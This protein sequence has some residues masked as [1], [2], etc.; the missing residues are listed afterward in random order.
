MG[1]GSEFVPELKGL[2]G[3]V[4]IMS[5]NPIL[6]NKFFAV[7]VSFLIHLAILGQDVAEEFNTRPRV[8][9]E[10]FKRGF[11][12]RVLKLI[13]IPCRVLLVFDGAR[14]LHKAATDAG[15]ADEK[16]GHL[17]RLQELLKRSNL[18]PGEIQELKQLKRKCVSV[19]ED[20]IASAVAVCQEE[21]WQ[22]VCSPFEADF[23]VR[24]L[25]DSLAL[26]ST[27]YLWKMLYSNCVTLFLSPPLPPLLFLS[28][29]CVMLER[30]GIVD[31]CITCDSDLFVLGSKLLV[32]VKSWTKEG[33]CFVIQRAAMLAN[34]GEEY[35]VG[36]PLTDDEALALGVLC[37]TFGTL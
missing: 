8:P 5:G 24:G 31:G 35:R 25:C 3:G 17:P 23:Q 32:F 19:T 13:S 22:Y 16:A 26:L 12:S 37:G 30:Q 6:K 18:N 28:P 4:Q 14:H 7:D 27:V 2:S 20:V 1:I 10:V 11:R 36:R 15:R 9:M 33:E 21:G 29:Q 34:L